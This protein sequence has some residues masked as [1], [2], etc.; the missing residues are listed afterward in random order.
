MLTWI[1]GNGNT[2]SLL[3]G[4]KNSAD[5]MIISIKIPQ[6]TSLNQYTTFFIWINLLL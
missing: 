4:V 1:W 2:C 5:T 6:K 3:V